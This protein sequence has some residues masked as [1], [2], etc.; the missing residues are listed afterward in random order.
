VGS[1]DLYYGGTAYDN[2]GGLGVQWPTESE[3]GSTEAVKV[4]K[5]DGLKVGKNE[6]LIVPIAELYDRKPAFAASEDLIKAH[7]P[8]PYVVLNAEDAKRL[9]FA[10]GDIVAVAFGAQRIEVAVRI[11][12]NAPAGAALLPRNL[13]DRPVPAV[14]VAGTI[15]KVEVA[16]HVA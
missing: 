14:P 13:S 15:N 16:A 12:G 9:D 1:G 8:A 3:Q 11:D 6:L 5:W 2:T 4:A 10:E 7:I